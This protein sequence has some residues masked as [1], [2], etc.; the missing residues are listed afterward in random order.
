MTS[1]QTDRVFEKL[2]ILLDEERAALLNGDFDAVSNLGTRK[3]RLFEKMAQA[4][5]G[6][7]PK[8]DDLRSKTARNQLL[9]EAALQGIRSVAERM[10]A[11]RRVRDTLE[12]YDGQG[13]KTAIA[14]PVRYKVEKRA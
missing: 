4:D 9:M 2:D 6:S 7:I 11:L 3:E 8:L 5:L 12:T 13:R 14:N 10:S 1:E